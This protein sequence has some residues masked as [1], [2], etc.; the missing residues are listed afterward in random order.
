MTVYHE[1]S[2]HD[3]LEVWGDGDI[4]GGITYRSETKVSDL[5]NVVALFIQWKTDCGDVH[6]MIRF[7]DPS[8]VE[9]DIAQFRKFEY[10]RSM[11]ISLTIDQLKDYVGWHSK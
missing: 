7:F 9:S 1:I 8:T 2:S 6:D 10:Y 4:T 3:V 11:V 5:A